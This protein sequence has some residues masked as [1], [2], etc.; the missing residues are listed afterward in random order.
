MIDAKTY[1]NSS[2]DECNEVSCVDY[3]GNLIKINKAT[4]Y[5]HVFG[6]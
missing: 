6:M 1:S 5:V 4:K 3:C 2:T